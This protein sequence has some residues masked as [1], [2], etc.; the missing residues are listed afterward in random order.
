[1]YA[2]HLA[3]GNTLLCHQIKSASI[4]RYVR[5]IAGFVALLQQRDIC[6]VHVLDT[7]LSP[8]IQSTF[9]EL[10]GWEDV[11]NRREPFTLEMLAAV[12][13]IVTNTNAP[14]TLWSRLSLI[15]SSAVSSL[16]F[17]LPNT[18][19]LAACFDPNYPVQNYCMETRGFCL[20]DVRFLG[21]QSRTSIVYPGIPLHSHTFS[22]VL[23]KVLDTKKRQQRRGMFIYYK[24]QPYREMLHLLHA[25]YHRSFYPHWRHP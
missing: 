22:Q 1:M 24:S 4:K 20:G 8:R 2:M 19:N 6:K 21:C 12:S 10:K 14:P 9:D 18:H 25:P 23:D 11:P 3:T 7:K 15:G 13:T 16:V 17:A 5:D